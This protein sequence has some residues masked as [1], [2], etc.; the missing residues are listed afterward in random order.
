MITRYGK[1]VEK[2]W[3][4]PMGP[5]GATGEKGDMGPTGPAGMVGAKGEKGE[6]GECGAIG[7]KGDKGDIGPTGPQGE[8]GATGPTGPAGENAT[9]PNLNATILNMASQELTTGTPISLLK[10]L[11]NNGLIVDS[12]SITVEKAGTYFVAYFVNK[13]THGSGTDSISLAINGVINTDTARPLNEDTTSSGQFVLNLQQ[14]S[15]LSLIPTIIN[16]TKIEANGG[17]SA[18][19]TV[20]KIA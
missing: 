12:T 2:H 3:Y 14:N 8:R 13:A 9:L 6:K 18:T 16:A 17:A 15:T 10:T 7:Q 19:L 11:T 20:I 1:Y 5:T 4:G